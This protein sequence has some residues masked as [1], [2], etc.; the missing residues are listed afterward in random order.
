MKILQ[1]YLLRATLSRL[2]LALPSLALLYLAV[3]LADSGRRL[4]AAA[5]WRIALEAALLHLPLVL[6]QAMPAA[7]LLAALLALSRLRERGELEAMAAAGARPLA[8]CLPLLAAGGIAAASALALDELLVPR[9][10]RA[11]DRRML[12]VGQRPRSP[13]TGLAAPAP[14]W[15][16]HGRWF[17][18]A[19]GEDRVALELDPA[20]RRR[21]ERIG[22]VSRVILLEPAPSARPAAVES[23]PPA[24]ALGARLERERASLEVG[25]AARPEAQS[26]LALRRRL[27]ALAA[28]GQAEPAEV[29]LLHAKLSFPAL[30]L[31]AALCA[32]GLGLRQGQ[33]SLAADLGL[34]L[35]S[36][37]ALFTLAAVGFVA[38][39]VGWLSPAAGAWLPVAGGLALGLLLLGGVGRGAIVR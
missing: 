15:T 16:R 9:C 38:G 12:G 3:D 25:A 32:C 28:A 21:F 19:T 30:C 29:L 11:L 35:L 23:G 33:R 22:T 7:L 1:R 27:A 14:P 13:L 8:C 5:G 39:R 24:A 31:C 10:E 18:L 34:G 2:A 20:P 36:L 4:A 37:L 6:V 17:L 26:A